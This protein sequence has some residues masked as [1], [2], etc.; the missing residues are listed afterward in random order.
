MIWEGMTMDNKNAT[1]K[2]LSLLV[3]NIRLMARAML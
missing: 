1:I 3:Y 2:P